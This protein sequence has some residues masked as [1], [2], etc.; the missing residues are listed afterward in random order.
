MPRSLALA[1]PDAHPVTPARPAASADW[2][3]ETH[4]CDGLTIRTYAMPH[5]CEYY[6]SPPQPALSLS[7]VTTGAMQLAARDSASSWVEHRVHQGDLFLHPPGSEAR[8]L[9]WQVQTTG[10][11]HTLNL[12]VEQHLLQRVAEQVTGQDGTQM[13]FRERNGFRDP[14]LQQLGLAL[15]QVFAQPTPG[16]SF[17]AETAAHML[18]V[19]L[20]CFY[21]DRTLPVWEPTRGLTARQLQRVHD[22]MQDH[23]KHDL[24]LAVLAQQ[25]GLSVYHFAR[26]FRQTTGESPHQYVLRQRVEQAQWL[27]ST[28]DM[29]LA[30]IAA[31]SGFATQSHLTT[32]FNGRLGLMPRAYRRRVR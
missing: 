19:H 5:A 4:P 12:Y 25:L 3:S 16:A 7:I 17:Y 11:A 24:T 21:A 6:V 8:E 22:Y 32:V 18:A 31:E 15:H 9:R 14:L 30:D 23:L 2:T 1:R 13:S 10:A 26:L 28:T 20:L 29:P 27:L